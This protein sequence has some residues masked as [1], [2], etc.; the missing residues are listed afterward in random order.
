MIERRDYKMKLHNKKGFTLIELLAVIVILSIL[1]AVAIPAVTGYINSSKK[2]GYTDNI[3]QY[4]S[5]ARYAAIS[6]EFELPADQYDATIIPFDLLVDKLDKSGKKSP[7]GGSFLE[8]ITGKNNSRTVVSSYVV[9]VQMGSNSDRPEYKYYAT[10]DDGQYVIGKNSQQ[11]IISEEELTSK[12]DYVTRYTGNAT[13]GNV[14]LTS[15]QVNT[16]RLILNTAS[17]SSSEKNYVPQ[18]LSISGTGN[19]TVR[20][21]AE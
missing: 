8:G 10:A 16:T 13:A 17:G 11:M 15:M 18:N 14:S 3:L 21:I 1:L 2:S 19:I 5:A 7:Y 12:S 6:G 20:N 9:I 4:I